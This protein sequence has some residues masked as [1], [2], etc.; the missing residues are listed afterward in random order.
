MRRIE[1]EQSVVLSLED[2]T[3]NYS[4]QLVLKGLNLEVQQGQIIG[5][6]GPNG[7][8]K[9]TTVRILLGLQQGYGGTA[10]L[11]GENIR[12][13]GAAYKGRIGYVPETAEVY[14]MLTAHEYLVFSGGCYGMDEQRAERKGRLLMNQFG[15]ADVF[16]AR[17]SSF[18]KGMRQK[19]LII[20]SLLHNPD[21]LFFDEPLSG[22]DANSVL[23]FKEILAKLAEQGKTIFYSSHIMDIVEK[24]SHRIVLL[25]DGQIA[26]DGTFE[27]LKAQNKEGS[28]EEIFNQLTGFHQHAQI[29]EDFVSIVEEV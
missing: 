26:A 29:A 28:L 10:R 23:V 21:L 9:S 13:S 24:I 16:D 17:L 27:E 8:G 1:T 22:L 18:S 14:D 5:Y 3:M 20:S 4:G 11:F 12:T 19:V 25:Y 6:I 15:L 2:L 7:A